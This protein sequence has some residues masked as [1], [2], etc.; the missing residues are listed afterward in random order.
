MRSCNNQLDAPSY[1]GEVVDTPEYPFPIFNPKS[2]IRVEGHDTWIPS[3][4]E[5]QKMQKKRA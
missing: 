5:V 4:E 2:I 3:C 1:V